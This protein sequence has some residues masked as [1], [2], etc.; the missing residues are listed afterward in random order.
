MRAGICADGPLRRRA[1]SVRGALAPTLNPMMNN[2]AIVALI[3]LAVIVAGAFLGAQIRYLL[4][5]HHLTEDTKNLVTV[6]T[7]VVATVSAL[8]LGLLISNANTTFTR[9][10]G[11]VTALSAEILRLDHILRRYGADAEPA[12][13]KLLQ[14]TERKA[15]DLFPD[16][17]ARVNLSDGS[18]YEL[19]QQLEDLILRLRPANA[20]D[21][22]WQNQAMLLAARIGESRWL[23]A[24][25]VG[26]GTPKLFVAVLVF[27]LALLFGSFGLF[28]PRNLTSAVIL[29]LCALAVAGAVGMFLKLEQGFG[30]IVRISSQPM[31][32]AVTQL[33]S[34]PSLQNAP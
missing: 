18:T 5:A 10:G 11:E 26:Q 15:D 24:Q 20:R 31:R 2:P 23:L 6:S 21:Q 29:T 3:V 32:Q 17:R 25:Q 1:E 13:S 33:Q 28:A 16:D 19:L 4:P 22:W 8:V 34:E 9:L 14:Y 7:A 27:W 12:R 30:G